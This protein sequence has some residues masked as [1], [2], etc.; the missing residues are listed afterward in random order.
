M[1]KNILRKLII[2]FTLIIAAPSWAQMI[3][4]VKGPTY[5]T[6][7][8]KDGNE[9]GDQF[10]V[11]SPEDDN[12]AMAIAELRKCDD[13]YCL[14]F[15][16]KIRKNT[17]LQSGYKLKKAVAKKVTPTDGK[18]EV[19]VENTV[20]GK[21]WV[22]VTYGAPLPNV[23]RLD[24]GLQN[25]RG[26]NYDIGLNLGMLPASLGG[27]DLK[28]QTL[29]L[30]TQYRLTDYVLFWKIIPK[31]IA[32]VGVIKADIDLSGVTKR[33]NDVNSITAMYGMVA[34]A[35]SQQFDSL[36]IDLGIGYSVNTIESP[37]VAPSK[38]EVSTP[39]GGSASLLMINA[40]WMF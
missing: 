6:T 4:E 14:Y 25:L 30:N 33:A 37:Q 17:S 27:I 12:K 29:G 40:S 1:Q 28:G 16:K 32:E 10:K 7:V 20:S 24:M 5:F 35:L 13:K 31:F 8:V 11:M 39:F 22:G 34:V 15:V 3:Y 36:F 21:K 38:N 23:F 18:T 19:A 9:V 2:G 26:S